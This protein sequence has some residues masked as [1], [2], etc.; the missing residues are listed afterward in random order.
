MKLK[1]LIVLLIPVVCIFI[2]I[3]C[4][5]A[6]TENEPPADTRNF[7]PVTNGTMYKFSVTQTDT[8]G[9]PSNGS[10]VSFINGVVTLDNKEY[11]VQLDSVFFPSSTVI[12]N[13]YFRKT[14]AGVYFNLDTTG[15]SNSIP[16]SLLSY[17][18]ISN[19]ITAFSFPLSAGNSWVGFNMNI[20]YLNI[21]NFNPVVMRTTVIGT[22][23]VTIQL[24]SGSTTL[25]AQKL[26][27]DI[28]VY[29]SPFQT[30]PQILSAFVWLVENI[31]IVKW[32][33]NLA[34]VNAFTG[35]GIDFDDS[36]RVTTQSLTEY[37]IAE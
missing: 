21:I 5:S 31:G 19:E 29:S 13:S 9:N 16:D 23:D 28:N 1:K 26:K 2:I 24:P 10:R 8:L 7:F 4:K 17:L 20:N 27:M 15:I 34:I 11:K 25:S 33:G 32:D 30:T 3:S 12:S 37:Y 6:T 18:T 35:G 22:E 36:T 14:S